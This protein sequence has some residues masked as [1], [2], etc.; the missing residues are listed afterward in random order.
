[1]G[2][3]PGVMVF[4]KDSVDNKTEALK[5]MYR[6]YNKAI[7][8]LNSTPQSEYIDLVVEKAGLPPATKEALVMPEYMKA[9][10]PNESDWE[11]SINWLNKKELVTEKYKYND[12][13]S[14]ILIK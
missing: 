2:I 12:V 14:D 5:A 6:A 4:T 13:V 3:N 7:D 8:Y 11:K 1:M 9:T 10:L